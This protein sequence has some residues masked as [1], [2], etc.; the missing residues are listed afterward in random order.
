[1][2]GASRE[3]LVAF[4]E[5][6]AIPVITTAKGKGLF[7]E[8]HPMSLGVFGVEGG[9]PLL[10]PGESAILLLGTFRRRPWVVTAGDEER[11]EARWVGTLTLTI[12]HRV[13][14]GEQASRFLRD[15]ATILEEPGLSLLY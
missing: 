1:M 14:D 10:N 2:T 4:C 11:I 5:R 8:D 3:R 6:H 12:D 15:V 7:P 13:L 9:T